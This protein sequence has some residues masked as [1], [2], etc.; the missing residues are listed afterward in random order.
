[1]A[2]AMTRDAAATESAVRVRETV[3]RHSGLFL[4][5]AA[6]L[7]LAG[8]VALI[9]PLLSSLAMTWFLGWLLIVSGVVQAISLVAAG[10]VPHY[11]LQLI[12]AVVSVVTGVVFV[13]N[14]GMAVTVMALLLVVYFMVE[15][16]SKVVLAL[17]VRPLA[18]WGWVLVSGLIGIGIAVFLIANPLLSFIALGIFVGVQ[19]ISEGVAL[20]WLA[21]QVRNT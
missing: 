9:F 4:V 2:E 16:I 3:R 6:L 10:R 20:G 17:T 5:Q 21:W 8:L 7:I 18:N 15:G 12:S 14:V 1:M 13:R 19:F 11:W